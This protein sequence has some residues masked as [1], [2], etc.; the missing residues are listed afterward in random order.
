MAGKKRIWHYLL[1]LVIF[2]LLIVAGIKIHKKRIANIANT[3]AE[4][5]APWALHFA[6]VKPCPV[7]LGFP[8]L[9]IVSTRE[10]LTI[11]PRISGRILEMGP[12]EG[13]KIKSG[14]LLV[15]IDTREIQDTINSLKAKYV[16]AKAEAKRDYDEFKRERE[17]LKNGGSNKSAVEARHTAFVAATQ[18]ANAIEH[19]IKSLLV[20]KSYGIIKSPSDGVIAKRM[21]EPGDMAVPSRPLYKIT[22]SRGALARVELPQSVLHRIHIGTSME[23][24]YNGR[25]LVFPITRIFPTVDARALGIAEADFDKIPFGLPSGARIACR[26]ILDKVSQGVQVAYGSLLCR[27]GSR[28][29]CSLFKIVTKN[30]KNIL[31]RVFVK[32]KL[33]GHNGIAVQAEQNQSSQQNRN[34]IANAQGITNNGSGISSESSLNKANSESSANNLN[35][36]EMGNYAYLKPG[37]KVVVAHESVLLQLKDGDSVVI[38]GGDLP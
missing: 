2:A 23:L 22:T 19:E 5:V 14:D 12:R 31:K 15:R 29:Q 24:Y 33:R 38:A 18:N 25:R 28:K 36:A 27:D 21:A 37:D 4:S 20:R 9:A 16:S 3:P 34:G 1:V 17:L 6:V 32:V 13:V 8:G 35:S 26:V 10:E 30:G 7:D 11:M